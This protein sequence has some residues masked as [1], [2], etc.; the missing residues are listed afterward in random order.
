MGGLKG[1]TALITGCNRGIG[2]AIMQELVAGGANIIACTRKQTAEQ[3]AFYRQCQ[4]EYGIQIYPIYFDLSDEDAIRIAL[5]EI[6]S[7]L[8]PQ[9][10]NLTLIPQHYN[11]TLFISS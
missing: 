7:S 4:S 11:L 5:K 6:Y 9:H 3:D 8:I 2:R 10:Y 1:K